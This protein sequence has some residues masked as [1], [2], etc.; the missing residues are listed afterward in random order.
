M[1][2]FVRDANTNDTCM[3]KQNLQADGDKKIGQ[4]PASGV[5]CFAYP[6]VYHV[7]GATLG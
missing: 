1:L 5:G 2:N 3:T 4:K 6:R 7:P